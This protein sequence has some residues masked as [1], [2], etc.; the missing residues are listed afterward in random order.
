MKKTLLFLLCITTFY[1]CEDDISG[2]IIDCAEMCRAPNVCIQNKCVTPDPKCKET[3]QAPNVCINGVC[4]DPSTICVPEC[5][6][7]ATCVNSVC[8]DPS[9]ECKPACKANELCVKGEC[10]VCATEICNG[11]CCSEDMLC[12]Q[13]IDVC[14]PIC[15]DGQP[16]C[17]E[18]CCNQDQ[19]CHSS[20]GCVDSCMEDQ[21]RCDGEF[22]T[23]CCKSNEVC[24][25]GV[26]TL[27][28]GDK[29]KCGNVCCED[30]YVCEA[31]ECLPVCHGQ[32]CGESKELCCAGG[33]L[34]IYQKCLPKGTDCETINDCELDE[35][36]ELTTNTCVAVEE[37]PNACIVKPKPGAFNPKLKWHWPTE[38]MP[39]GAPEFKPEFNQVMR[40]PIV[41]N[42]T[43]D[44]GD[45]KID[46]NDVPEVVFTAFSRTAGN[47]SYTGKTALRVISGDDGRDLAV[48]DTVDY[49][50]DNVAAAKVNNDEYPEIVSG[51]SIGKT[52]ILNLLP[53]GDG[54][55]ELK[56]IAELQEN[57]AKHKFVNLDGGKYPHIVSTAGII[58]YNEA[59]DTYEWR[60]QASLGNS[61]VADIDGD[62]E[63]EII[64][65]RI[66]NKDCEIIS[67]DTVTGT[68]VL[69]D[70]DLSS[71][72]SNGKLVPE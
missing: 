33:E 17:Y 57:S 48:A 67:S 26:C 37:N 28:C 60:C 62:G 16:Q 32:R 42:L 18:E 49:P 4:V 44:N 1:A 61:A 8:V 9:E 11:V 54:G 59:E 56:I 24:N 29:I 5:T 53:T 72:T 22:W 36:C 12:D 43:D 47:G 19:L 58:Q 25:E 66:W 39:G 40:I 52:R 3:C 64:G 45:G 27:H 14:A 65:T 51:T 15:D 70:I 41:I 10:Q 50:Y 55:Y 30:N 68:S 38:S 6:A 31:G 2:K 20:L 35:F 13:Y 21:H 7:P 46:E 63:P 34:C 69:A 23:S 71:D